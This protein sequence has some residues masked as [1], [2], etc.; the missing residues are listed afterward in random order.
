MHRATLSS[1]PDCLPKSVSATLG[2]RRIFL[3]EDSGS[4]EIPDWDKDS[5][6]KVRDT[7]NILALTRTDTKPYFGQKP[8]L[9]PL[10]HLIGTAAGWGGNPPEG[11]M[12]ALGSVDKNDGKTPYTVTVKDVPVHGFWSVTVYNK[13][14]FMEPNDLGVNSYNNVTAKGNDDGSFT[15]NF[16][17]CDDGRINC[18]PVV[19]GWNYAVR[20]YQPNEEIISGEWTFPEFEPAT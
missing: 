3:Q 10:Y 4:F 7:I 16:G 5:L 8:L 9:N 14:G 18:L 12:Y 13:D 2:I 19:D 1:P 6:A 15:L 17:G 20:M 11:A